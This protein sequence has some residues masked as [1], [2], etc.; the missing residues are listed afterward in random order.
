MEYQAMSEDRLNDIETKLAYLDMQF[1]EM[2]GVIL[3]QSEIIQ[4][5][6]SKIDMLQSNN[7][8]SPDKGLSPS[9]IAERDKPPHY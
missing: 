9:E 7:E 3:E 8:E 2:N 1:E 4:R 6:K 5:L